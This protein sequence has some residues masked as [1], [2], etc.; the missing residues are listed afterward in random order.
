[1]DIIVQWVNL[2]GSQLAAWTSS[3]FDLVLEPGFSLSFSYFGLLALPLQ[4]NPRPFK[5]DKEYTTFNRFS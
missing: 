2:S 1:M 5:Y 4:K 3:F